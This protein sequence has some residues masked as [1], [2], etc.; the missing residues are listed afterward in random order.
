MVDPEHVIPLK[1]ETGVTLIVAV[2]VALPILV[3]VKVP[4]FP[5]PL[6]GKPI[7]G[8]LLVQL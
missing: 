1:T 8:W 3:A 7:E 2:R 4:M 5:V 6:A